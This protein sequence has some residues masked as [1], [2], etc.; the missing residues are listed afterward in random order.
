MMKDSLKGTQDN[1][2]NTL[3][4][5]IYQCRKDNREVVLTVFP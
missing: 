1:S 4:R 5:Q 3:G 2:R